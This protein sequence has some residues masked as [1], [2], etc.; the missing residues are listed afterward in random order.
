MIESQTQCTIYNFT[1]QL[2]IKIEEAIKFALALPEAIELPHFEKT[3]FRVKKK[4]FATLDKTTGTAVVKL[5]AVDQS[6]FSDPKHQIIYPVTGAWGKQGWT[7]IELKKVGKN[8][9]KDALTTSYRN[10][11][12]KALIEKIDL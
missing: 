5:S 3:S 12:P 6:V 10:V 8:L 2:M 11:A 1:L 7:K 9:F 4:I